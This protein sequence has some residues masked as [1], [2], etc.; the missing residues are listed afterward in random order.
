MYLSSVPLFFN[1]MLAIMAK[2]EFN[3]D[4]TCRGSRFSESAVNPR[5]SA[6]STVTSTRLPLK[7][8]R[9]DILIIPRPPLR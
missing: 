1:M 5:I 9:P 8:F 2:Y 7:V 4:T 3:I 6:K